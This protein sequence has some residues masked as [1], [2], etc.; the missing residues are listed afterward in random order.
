MSRLNIEKKKKYEIEFTR[1]YFATGELII[2]AKNREEAIGKYI[3]GDYDSDLI[4]DTH[5]LQGGD[6]EFLSI[7]E[8][9]WK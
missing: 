5:S 6:D 4:Q 1:E 9:K 7:K 2:E 8:V 3:S